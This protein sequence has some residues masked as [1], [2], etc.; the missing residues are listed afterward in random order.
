MKVH[1]TNMNRSGRR[2]GRSRVALVL[3]IGA[4]ALPAGAGANF[5]YS[6]G[7]ANES[8]TPP[9]GGSDYSS[10]NAI[11]GGK[12]AS[13]GSA[14][15]QLSAGY[16]TP[17]AIMGASSSKPALVSSPADDGFDWLSAAVGAGAAM[18]LVA[19]GGAAFL[20][21]GRRTTRSATAS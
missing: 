8:S 17:N 5:G 1:T 13:S 14:S 20:T 10:I 2:M 7:N 9:A 15:R 11:M 16:A 6:S 4:L 12:E 18:S 3:A 21:F 19:L